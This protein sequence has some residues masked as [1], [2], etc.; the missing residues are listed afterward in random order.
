MLLLIM[1]ISQRCPEID[2]AWYYK[3]IVNPMKTANY[4][5][6]EHIDATFAPKKRFAHHNQVESGEKTLY[7]STDAEKH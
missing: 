2:L 6:Q 5:E 1:L 7:K 4:R 3:V